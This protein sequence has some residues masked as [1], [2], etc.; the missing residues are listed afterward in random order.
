MNGVSVGTATKDGAGTFSFTSLSLADGVQSFTAR[1]TRAGVTSVTSAALAL[2]VDTAAASVL[3]FSPADDATNVAPTSNI[4]LTFSE[5]V[6]A[7]TGNIVISLADGTTWRTIAVT[8]TEV[9]ISGAQ[10]TINPGVD[11]PASTAFYL[12]IDAGA[13]TDVAGNSFPGITDATVFNFSTAAGNVFTGTAGVDNYT[14]TAADEMIYG[15]GGNDSLSG[16]G[17]DDLIDGGAGNDTM[18]GG[19][20]GA[21]GDTV[22]YASATSAVTVSLASTASQNTGGAGRDTLSGFE[23]LVGS[24][25]GD[26]LTGSSG[27]NII[28]GGLGADTITGGQGVDTMTGG[29]GN[30]VFDFNALNETGNTATTRD[31]IT[32]F[33]QGQDRIDLSTID[34]SA[35][36]NNNNAFVF[37]GA[38]A[39]FGTSTSGEIRFAQENG[40]TIIYADTDSDSTPEFQIALNGLYTLTAADFIL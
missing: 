33:Q 34:A 9:T 21:A 24:D 35:S 22:S 10:V 18:N 40:M 37:R 13:L 2:T 5:T 16:A 28:N 19:A 30:D 11:M 1:A 39:A 27:N 6:V 31:T 38:I 17:G 20:N 29:A 15:L 23:N 8:S 3:S 7:G 25:F 32:D 12:R 36:L 14:G 26:R 4:V